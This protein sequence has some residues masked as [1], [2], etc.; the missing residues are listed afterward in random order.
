MK[1]KCIVEYEY[2]VEHKPPVKAEIVL[3]GDKVVTRDITPIPK[4]H[5]RLC[6]LDAA[7]ECVK[8]LDDCEDKIYAIGLFDW[9]CSKRV[10]IEADKE[11]EK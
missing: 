10:L 8:E 9:A 1:F 6:D 4:G 7:L 11:V 3:H 5:G 2:P